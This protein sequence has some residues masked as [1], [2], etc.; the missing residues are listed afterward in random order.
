MYDGMAAFARCWTVRTCRT[1]RNEMTKAKILLGI[2]D[3]L[4]E[5]KTHDASHTN[6]PNWIA[7]INVNNCIVAIRDERRWKIT[8]ERCDSS[9][10]TLSRAQSFWMRILWPHS[11][12][13]VGS[14]NNHSS[15]RSL[16]K[17]K[18][19]FFDNSIRSSTASWWSSSSF[20]PLR[21]V[22]Q[23]DLTDKMS[24]EMDLWR[25]DGLWRW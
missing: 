2:N 14:Q 16:A 18:N 15:I 21:C 1:V 20:W 3:A 7:S 9:R 12:T 13:K 11:S 19:T 8:F 22:H 17:D 24:A 4:I 5:H 23:F 25:G 6:L 10:V